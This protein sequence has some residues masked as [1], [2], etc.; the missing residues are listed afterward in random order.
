MLTNQKIADAALRRLGRRATQPRRKVVRHIAGLT[1]S[2][3]AESVIGDLPTIGR[4]TIYRT[5][6][7]LTD[8]GALCKTALPDG[9]PLYSFDSHWHHHHLICSSCESVD[10]FEDPSLERLLGELGEQMSGQ[11]IGHRVDLFITCSDCLPAQNPAADQIS[12]PLSRLS[13]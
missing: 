6:K 9:T 1:G 8:A 2:F 13:S 7:L 3:R 5:L 4:A 10:E 11:L 12:Q